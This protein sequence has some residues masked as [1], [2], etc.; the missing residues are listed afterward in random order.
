MNHLLEPFINKFDIVSLDDICIYLETPEQH[1]VH[2]RLV[3]QKL[4]EHQ[5]FIKIPKCVWGRKETEYHL[6][7][8][9]GNGTLRTALDKISA[10]RDWPLSEIQKQ[11]KSFVQFCSYY[12]KFIDH[13]S[14]CAAPLTNMCRKNLP[15]KV[16]H[17]NATQK[18]L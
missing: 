11:I 3:L 10:V 8:I 1:I 4:H 14:N 5:L 15:G 13:F 12:G 18:R 16:V 17:T 2:L 9:V 6:G 7:V